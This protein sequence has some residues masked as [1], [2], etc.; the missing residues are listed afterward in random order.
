MMQIRKKCKH[1]IQHYLQQ[2]RRY[3]PLNC[4]HCRYPGLKPRKPD[5]PA[6]THYKE[7]EESD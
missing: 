7:R 1:F 6:C 5:T 2:G 4:G 3:S